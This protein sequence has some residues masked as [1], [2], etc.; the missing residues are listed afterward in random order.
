MTSPRIKFNKPLELF[1]WLTIERAF[2]QLSV[3]ISVYP[4]CCQHSCVGL[5]SVVSAPLFLKIDS[6]THAFLYYLQQNCYLLLV[7]DLFELLMAL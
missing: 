2:I 6:F 4:L 7:D 5:E 3:L 1:Q